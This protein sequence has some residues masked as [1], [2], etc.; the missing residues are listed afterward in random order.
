[1][2]KIHWE[3]GFLWINT[4]VN[5]LPSITSFHSENGIPFHETKSCCLRDKDSFQIAFHNSVC[6]RLGMTMRTLLGTIFIFGAC[7]LSSLGSNSLFSF[8]N[9]W[10]GRDGTSVLELKMPN[11]WIVNRRTNF[12]TL[13]SLDSQQAALPEMWCSHSNCK[14]KKSVRKHHLN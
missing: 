12:C 10:K 2:W 8:W 14:K 5:L 7:G 1:M 6:S 3:Q 11:W 13:L 4:C 9:K